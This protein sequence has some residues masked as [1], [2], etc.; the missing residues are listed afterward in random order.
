MAF[1]YKKEY[2]EFYQPKK[3][4]S[5]VE[6]PEMRYIAVRGEGDPNEEGG[7]YKEAI[8]LLYAIAFTIKMSKMGSYHIEGYFDYVVPPLE[9]FWWQEDTVGVDYGRKEDFCWISVIRLPDFVTKKDVQ[10][11]IE[12]AGKKKGQDFSKVE[13]M[14]IKEGLCVQCMHIGAYDDEPATVALM[15]RFLNENGYKN[16]FTDKRRHHEI[17]LSDARRVT[18]ERL[19]TVIRHPVRK[20]GD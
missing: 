1:D 13:F 2:K 16:D 11:A 3:K 5:M 10:W 6:V 15:D 7:A 9:G 17:Y 8:G 18:P 19:K 12:E 4:P 20:V 14:T